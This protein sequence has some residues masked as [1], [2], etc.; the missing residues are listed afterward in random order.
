MAILEKH[1]LAGM[2]LEYR[3]ECGR[4]SV[5][6]SLTTV[7]SDCTDA[8]SQESESIHCEH[9]LSLESGGNIVKARTAW[10][11]KQAQDQGIVTDVSSAA[12]A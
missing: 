2:T 6:E 10:R 5:V 7:Y 4:D 8:A 9:L 11:P 1:E 12:H 3:R